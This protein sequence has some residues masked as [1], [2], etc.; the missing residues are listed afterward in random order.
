MAGIQCRTP[1]KAHCWGGGDK[2]YQI[3]QIFLKLIQCKTLFSKHE[4]GATTQ[5][6]N[7]VKTGVLNLFY[8]TTYKVKVSVVMGWGGGPK[9]IKFV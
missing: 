4:K 8:G 3:K 1:K 5:F 7:D 9:N 2:I 6:I